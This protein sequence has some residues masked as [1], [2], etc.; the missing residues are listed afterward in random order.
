MI[1]KHGNIL[2]VQ[3]GFI[4]H[5]CNAQGVMGGGV[6]WQIR[7][8]YP[9]AYEAYRKAYVTQGLQLGQIIPVWVTNEL[10]IVN[11][12]TQEYFG[13]DGKR[14]VDYDAV[15]L[16]FQRTATYR[17]T[18]SSLLHDTTIH[19]PQIGA[20][21]GGGDW[22]TIQSVINQALPDPVPSTLWLY[23]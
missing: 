11:A 21:L 8:M 7:Q 17:M 20:G 15:R 14:Y 1:I 16:A 22:N 2:S 10:C 6:A 23:P 18:Y 5:G 4:V 9:T 12:I 3:E 13:N 19:Y